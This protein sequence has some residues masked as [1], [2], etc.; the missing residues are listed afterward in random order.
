MMQ[1]VPLVMHLM[2]NLAYHVTM[3]HGSMSTHA[4]N[5]LNLTVIHAQMMVLVHALYVMI[6]I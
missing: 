4:Q 3:E 1:L 6:I 5:V 2:T